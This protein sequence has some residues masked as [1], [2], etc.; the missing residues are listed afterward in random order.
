MYTEDKDNNC[1]QKGGTKMKM[2]WRFKLTYTWRT[3][4]YIEH[5][6]LSPTELEAILAIVKREGGNECWST[7]T[8]ETFNV[9]ENTQTFSKVIKALTI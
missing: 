5:H 7:V 1:P 9:D 2:E 4:D 6:Y 8:V 3:G